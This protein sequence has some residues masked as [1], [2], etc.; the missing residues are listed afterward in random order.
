M[1]PKK[2]TRWG[3]LRGVSRTA[4]R[5]VRACAGLTTTRRSTANAERGAL[6]FT[7][8]R[9]LESSSSNS[10][11]YDMALE[12]T[13]RFIVAVRPDARVPS[14]L[15]ARAP[16][17]ALMTC[18][19]AMSVSGREERATNASKAVTSSGC[20]AEP[21]RRVLKAQLS[22]AERIRLASSGAEGVDSSTGVTVINASAIALR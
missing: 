8:A 11:A 2:A 22:N 13:T 19:L 4:F 17:V 1:Q 7:F 3:P 18:G 16:S 10:T 12:S 6:H 5:S 20:S 14:S 21:R 15:A 9:G